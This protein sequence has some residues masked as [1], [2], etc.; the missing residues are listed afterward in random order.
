MIFGPVKVYLTTLQHKNLNCQVLSRAE[1]GTVLYLLTTCP[2]K[3]HMVQSVVWDSALIYHLPL[4][5]RRATHQATTT[6]WWEPSKGHPNTL[7]F[8][9]TAG[10]GLFYNSQMNAVNPPAH[11]HPTSYVFANF[12]GT[13]IGAAG[14]NYNTCTFVCVAYGRGLSPGGH[15]LDN[16][17]ERNPKQPVSKNRI[18]SGSGAQQNPTV[19][20]VSSLLGTAYLN[21]FD[22]ENAMT[23]NANYV[24]IDARVHKMLR[25]LLR[26]F[27]RALTHSRN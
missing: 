15:F 4:N 9:Q 21:T 11:A 22:N 26:L 7:L 13:S 23:S 14:L 10:Q 17:I 8:A 16:H 24:V 2:T 19:F 12:A 25:N 18:A 6:S 5:I 27:Q 3:L 20:R 1:T